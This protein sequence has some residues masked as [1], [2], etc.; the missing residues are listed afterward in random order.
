MPV[1]RVLVPLSLFCLLLPGAARAG[2]K[3]AVDGVTGKI[4]VQSG[5]DYNDRQDNYTTHYAADGKITTTLAEIFDSDSGR[6]IAVE[7]RARS[8]INTD[9]NFQNS[10]VY[11]SAAIAWRDPGIGMFGTE[12]IYGTAGGNDYQQAGVLGAAFFGPFTLSGAAR[13]LDGELYVSDGYFL[14]ASLNVYVTENIAT[15]VSFNYS[16]FDHDT[17][18]QR[19]TA[20]AEWLA[21]PDAPIGVSFYTR[22]SYRFD[23][24]GRDNFAALAGMSFYFSERA[25]TLVRR[26]RDDNL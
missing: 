25:K 7:A 9:K 1:S 8:Q 13:Y 17:Y 15:A 10:N 16:E 20:Q 3:P 4:S 19:V 24:A 26:H 14:R 11:G 22:A 18:T 21:F 12:F 6:S 5:F 2:D 23:P